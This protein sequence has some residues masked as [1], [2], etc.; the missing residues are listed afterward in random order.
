MTDERTSFADAAARFDRLARDIKAAQL[1]RTGAKLAPPA[2]APGI[3]HPQAAWD[4]KYASRTIRPGRKPE[5]QPHLWE[6]SPPAGPAVETA[7]PANPPREAPSG[8]IGLA[9]GKPV[10]RSWVRRLF[11]G[12]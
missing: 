8:P 11:R 9:I 5:A 6:V 7:P 2:P 1:V 12:R 4:R 10:R 3:E